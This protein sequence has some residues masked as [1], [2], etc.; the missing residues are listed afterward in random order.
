MPSNQALPQ[1]RRQWATTYSS[2][3]PV[4]VPA[5]SAARR[6]REQP[7]P[8]EVTS[9]VNNNNNRLL[10]AVSHTELSR[11]Q[12]AYR[13]TTIYRSTTAHRFIPLADLQHVQVCHTPALSAS[14][15]HYI[16]TPKQY[17]AFDRCQTCQTLQQLFSEC[18]NTCQKAVVIFS[19][20]SEWFIWSK[21]FDDYQTWQSC[22]TRS[23]WIKADQTRSKQV[24]LDQTRSDWIRG[25]SD[26]F[27]VYQTRSEEIK[28][29]QTG[30]KLD[31][32][33]W[34]WIIWQPSDRT[35]LSIQIRVDQTRSF[36]NCQIRTELSKWITV[37]Q[38]RSETCWRVC[39]M[40][41]GCQIC[42][43]SV[44][45]VTGLLECI[46]IKAV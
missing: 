12:T 40:I 38:T 34:N 20:L 45:D 3:N 2:G 14:L 5:T 33:R 35:E 30:S 27:K 31:Q 15:R 24:R 18:S 25:R 8:G 43:T 9:L 26:I 7:Y 22:Q 21:D 37:D 41:W 29:D 46:S 36:H 39:Q 13:A 11:H 17:Q 44:S 1:A 16:I 4:C 32:N 19:D 23:A 6:Q 42:T 10:T 28:V